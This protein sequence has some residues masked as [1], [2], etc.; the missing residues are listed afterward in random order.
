[1]SLRWKI[2]VAL[3]AL[4]AVVTVAIGWFS[5]A[6]TADRLAAEVDRSL[7]QVA[8]RD[9]FRRLRE[10]QPPDG[11]AGESLVVVQ[12]VDPDGRVYVSP[13]A[14]VLPVD[15]G[16]LAIA[17]GDTR[18]PRFRTVDVDGSWY[19]MLTTP[20]ERG[21]GAAVVGRSLAEN[22]R[23][24]ASLRN[25]ILVAGLVAVV[26]ALALG[27]LIA[28][29]VTRRLVRLTGAAEEV[30]TTGSLD[31]PVPVRGHDEAGRLGVAFNEMLV[32]LARS[33]DGQ[34]RLVQDAGHELRTPLTSLRAN[35]AVLRRHRGLDAATVDS[36]VAD[37][38]E[39]SRELTDLVNELVAL[40]TDQRADEPVE[41]VDLVALAERVAERARRRT[42]RDVQVDAVPTVLSGRPAALERAVGNL[43]DNAAKFADDGPIVVEV[44]PGRLVVLDRGPG[45]DPVDLP[46]VFD[47][48]YRA[49]SARSR[50]GS[51]LGLA[52]V[53]DVAASHGGKAVAANRD[54]GGAAIGMELPS[55]SPV[56]PPPTLSPSSHPG[57]ALA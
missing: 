52:I 12:L 5:Y 53:H 11:P 3:A 50:P 27:W 54:G 19:R 14:T 37:L 45:L 18:Q 23:V 47:R 31:V 2:V 55:R 15:D 42:G 10:P 21:E 1:M 17:S 56:L 57:P 46:H 48:F 16:D 38:D 35:I 39:E 22:E 24:L 49:V 13:G 29:Q 34:Q 8:G 33:R 30:A 43:V 7:A 36:V 26:V 41:D 20:V 40:A 6:T 28:R 51:G 44:R 9:L 32:A 4:G 25:R